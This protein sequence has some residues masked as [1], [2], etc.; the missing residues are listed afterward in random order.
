MG[1]LPYVTLD[2]CFLR[3]LASEPPC[4]QHAVGH[5]HMYIYLPKRPPS[6]HSDPQDVT[7]HV[8]EP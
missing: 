7:L 5:Q 2:V 1:I 3:G 6:T 8:I 4:K